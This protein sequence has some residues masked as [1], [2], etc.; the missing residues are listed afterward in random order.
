MTCAELDRVTGELAFTV[1]DQSGAFLLFS[2]CDGRQPA[3]LAKSGVLTRR[4]PSH[5]EQR[6]V[7]YGRA[8][9]RHIR[10]D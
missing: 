5:L 10:R 1:N 6:D 9:A 2:K 3:L 4:A 7:D 8:V